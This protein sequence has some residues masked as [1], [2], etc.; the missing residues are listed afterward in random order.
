VVTL[1]KP[2][3]PEHICPILEVFIFIHEW[4]VD[5]LLLQ[6]RVLCHELRIN[7]FGMVLELRIKKVR[8]AWNK[9]G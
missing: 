9:E 8:P 2:N 4:I 1:I 7:M 6:F 3:P 5:R